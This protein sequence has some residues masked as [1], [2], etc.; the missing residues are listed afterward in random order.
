VVTSDRPHPLRRRPALRNS[1]SG[2][3]HLA[4]SDSAR[5]GSGVPSKD[6]RG[7][8]GPASPPASLALLVPLHVLLFLQRFSCCLLSVFSTVASAPLISFASRRKIR[9]PAAGRSALR[10]NQRRS[11]VPRPSRPGAGRGALALRSP[12][13]ELRSAGRRCKGC[14]RSEVPVCTRGGHCC[15][16][17]ANR[18]QIW[19][20]LHCC[21]QPAS[22][23][24]TVSSLLST[25]DKIGFSECLNGLPR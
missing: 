19:P 4:N 1:S 11:L 6:K 8:M 9:R 25:I 16:A 12:E 15:I 3:A 18:H 14:G 13:G 7:L 20:L 5:A 22:D 24:A 17:A 21:C 2:A 10:N 23:L